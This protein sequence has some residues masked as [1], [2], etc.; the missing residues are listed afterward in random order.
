MT[1]DGY[2]YEAPGT[3]TMPLASTTANPDRKAASVDY[4]GPQPHPVIAAILAFTPTDSRG[5]VVYE[6]DEDDH[7]YFRGEAAWL[8]AG[9]AAAVLRWLADTSGWTTGHL[10]VPHALA[11]LA[12]EVEAAGTD[13]TTRSQ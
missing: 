12:D 10:S 11:A 2:P 6:F 3:P 1:S 9:Q 7:A 13:N 8:A 4:S 5:L